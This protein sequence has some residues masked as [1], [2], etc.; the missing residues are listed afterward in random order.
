MN[1]GCVKPT[2]HFEL[3]GRKSATGKRVFVSRCPPEH[4]PYREA[5][6]PCG[7]CVACRVSRRLDLSLRL[8]H[9]SQMH[10]ASWFVTL[11]Y[12]D[13]H[14]PYGNTLVREHPSKFVRSVRKRTRQRWRYFL[15][16]EYGS[17]FSRPHYH[18]ILFGHE[19]PDKRFLYSREGNHFFQSDVLSEAWGRGIVE[20]STVS[21]STMMYVT[22]YHVDKVNGD[23]AEA[24]YS[25]FVESSG[26]L[27]EREPE[28]ALMSNRPGIGATWFDRYWS[29]CYP[30]GFVTSAGIRYRPPRY[31]DRLLEARDP[32][33]F[34]EVKA[35]R[36]EHLPSLAELLQ[37]RLDAKAA[38]A[39]AE[40]EMKVGKRL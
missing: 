1:R 11:T 22:K 36:L 23:R 5:S 33:L 40:L 8:S 7:G 9:E 32:A 17:D 6:R 30:K 16:G 39:L 25:W 4:V 13:D 18:V 27:V 35:S 31:Y 19:L 20:V 21:P 28:F 29:D 3:L 14:V 24:H 2:T 15:A 38:C 34:E 10:D 12:D 26:E 37:D